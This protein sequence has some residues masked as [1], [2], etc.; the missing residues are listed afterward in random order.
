MRVSKVG[1]FI[2]PGQIRDRCHHHNTQNTNPNQ[3]HEDLT[4]TTISKKKRKNRKKS[5]KHRRRIAAKNN[6]VPE[7]Q[8]DGDENDDQ[9]IQQDMEDAYAEF[10]GSGG[11]SSR[12][13]NPDLNVQQPSQSDLQDQFLK[14]LNHKW[15]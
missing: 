2:T 13:I 11:H 1:L 15:D 14:T 5:L 8:Q 4:S 12:T 6:P 10:I 7:E 9:M 3:I